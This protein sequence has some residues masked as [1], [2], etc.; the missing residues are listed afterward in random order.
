MTRV[1][2][3]TKVE[4][5]DPRL[6]RADEI[7]AGVA[8]ISEV[9]DEH[10]AQFREQGYLLVRDLFTA[11][12][13]A[14]ALA[15]LEV[16]VLADDPQC[17][18]VWFEGSIRDAVP[19]R[20]PEGKAH[21]VSGDIENL[22]LGQTGT[23]MP[24]L[25]PE[26]RARYVR[27]FNQFAEHHLPLR[28]MLEK[29][30]LV[31]LVETLIG[32]PAAVLQEM[33]MVKPPKGREKPWHQDHAY[34][35]YP[36]DTK[37]IGTWISLGEATPENGCMHVLAGAHLDGAKVHWRRRDWQICDEDAVARTQTAVPARAGDVLFFDSK[38]P[39]GTPI[40]R[41]DT[42]R[43]ALQYHFIAASAVE[44]PDEERLAIFGHEGKDVTC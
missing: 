17:E 9:T 40:N 36:L 30:E 35:N 10:M 7:A 24:A 16:M 5:H 25:P 44:T 4:D 43:W 12:E 11:D 29:P 39:H 14:A 2:L 37:I 20:L 42:Y 41:S 19:G 3:E 33:A 27:K 34:F 1:V 8:G 18:G 28:A 38:L 22:A 32:E 6:Y 31:R 21:E 23:T 15:E 13:V 26:V